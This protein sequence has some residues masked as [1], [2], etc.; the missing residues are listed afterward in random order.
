MTPTD[1]NSTPTPR[2]RR[3][4]WGLLAGTVGTLALGVLTFNVWITSVVNGALGT[5]A[6]D[7]TLAHVRLDV[8]QRQF[9][10][11]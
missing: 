2:R 3:R 10:I 7:A 1:A 8:G 6:I 9:T 5:T 11:K 4:L